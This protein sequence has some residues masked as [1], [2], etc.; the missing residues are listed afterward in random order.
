MESALLEMPIRVAQP[1][2]VGTLGA[3][4]ATASGETRGIKRKDEELLRQ[5]TETLDKQL[6]SAL[7]CRTPQEFGKLRRDVWEKYF[8]ARR[9][10][11]DAIK[12]VIPK[13]VI[14]MMRFV[15]TQR[16]M[17]EL[18]HS[19]NV[20]FG[21]DI[22]TQF[23][24]TDWLVNKMQC[25]A[26]EIA[27]VGEPTDRDADSRLHE[28]FNLYTAWGQFHYDCVLASMKFERPIPEQIQGSIRDGLRAWVNAC[29]IVE[30]A[31]ALRV[32]KGSEIQ[33]EVFDQP[34][35]EEDQELLDSSMKDL[36]AEC[37]SD[38]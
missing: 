21:E 36:D 17:E 9:A 32:E 28:D 16:L 23:E 5:I 10:L 19:R 27:K 20:L 30:E 13:E 38:L 18:G 24:F 6:L 33:L 31:L 12:L 25:V 34:W 15:T 4:D 37:R 2:E 1:F 29:S 7:S 14:E 8:C 22:A 3:L 11:G 35:D 26:H